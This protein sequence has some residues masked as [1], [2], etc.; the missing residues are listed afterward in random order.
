MNVAP[1]LMY[2]AHSSLDVE[3]AAL[4]F[5]EEELGRFD[6]KNNWETLKRKGVA[7]TRIRAF[8]EALRLD[9]S[10]AE[11]AT[12]LDRFFTERAGRWR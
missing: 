4:H 3:D 8:L 11:I 7:E 2:R 9:N 10:P 12:Y 5:V 1:A 6:A